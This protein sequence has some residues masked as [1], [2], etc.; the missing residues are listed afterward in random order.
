MRS[1]WFAEDPDKA[2]AERYFLLQSPLWVAAVAIVVLTGALHSWSDTSYLI[3][4]IA[5]SLP[6]TVGPL[7]FARGRAFTGGAPYW[8]RFNAWVAIV[9]FFGTY[10]GTHYFFDLMG[11][12]YAFPARW[13]FEAAYVGKSGQHVP[14]FMYPLTQAYFVTYYTSLVVAHRGLASK[15]GGGALGSAALV[16]VLSYAVA[17]AETFFMATDLMTDLFSYEKRD[18]MLG[19][20]SFGYATYFVV[21]LPLV[22]RIDLGGRT[23]TWRVV[24]SAL[25]TCMGVLL[26]LEAWARVVGRL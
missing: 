6:A 15:L 10:F 13:V 2:W 8:L 16:L 3:F 19:L 17:F 23:S 25:A 14:I 7:C 22:R 11:M 9:V 26:L 20:G 1:S 21:G 18:K 24:E 12:R 5:V 4:S